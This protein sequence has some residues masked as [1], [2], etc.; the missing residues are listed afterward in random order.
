M[1]NRRAFLKQASALTVFASGTTALSN[2]TMAA[3][4]DAKATTLDTPAEHLGWKPHWIKQGDGKGGWTLRLAQIQFLHG[5]DG[6]TA[7][8]QKGFVQLM[9]FGLQVMDNRE[10]ALIGP[11]IYADRKPPLHQKPALA[12][13]QDRGNTWTRPTVIDESDTCF[14]RTNIFTYLGKGDL[15][16]QTTGKSPIQYFSRDYGRTWPERQPLQSASNGEGYYNEGSALV[17][18]DANGV[19][20]RI[21]VIGYNYPPGKEFPSDPV[22]CMLRWS[23]DGGRTWSNKTQPGWGWKEEYEGKSYWHG[24]DEGSITR[25]KNGWLVAAI[26]T[27]MPAKFY[28]YHNDNAEGIGVSVSKD[29]GKT[30]TQINMLY[31]A[32]RMH[33]HLIVQPGGEIVLTHVMRQDINRGQLASYSR[34]AGAVVSYDHGLTWDMAHRYLLGDFEFADG[35]PLALACGHQ[36]SALLDDGSILTTFAHYPSKGACLIKWRPTFYRPGK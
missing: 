25:A 31:L 19:A 20:K 22:V 21:G 6:K 9:P 32:G 29:E 5:G 28:P 26:R 4:V 18:R 15:L 36:S 7:H 17:D 35:T 16:F 30:W 3:R 33:I 24:G 11:L 2:S 8:D 34:G 14:G 23:E 27:D 13:S 1:S 12:F 10:I